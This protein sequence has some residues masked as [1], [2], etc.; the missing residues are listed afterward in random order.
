[1]YL[2]LR[3][4]FIPKHVSHVIVFVLNDKSF[5]VNKCKTILT[6]LQYC[7]YHIICP[8]PRPTCQTPIMT[9]LSCLCQGVVSY[10]DLVASLGIN[11]PGPWIA[12]GPK[13]QKYCETHYR[14]E[15]LLFLRQFISY[16]V[17]IHNI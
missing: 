8:P 2:T 9:N 16:I 3:R 1:M 15:E 13:K 4:E 5:P 7:A 14:G 11:T 6:Q 12:P 10:K 17:A